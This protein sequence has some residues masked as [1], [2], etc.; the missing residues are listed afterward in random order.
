MS[1]EAERLKAGRRE[2]ARSRNMRQ[3][4]LRAARIVNR[5]V[6]E[7]LH[8]RGYG[9]L[10]STHTTLLSNMPLAGGTISETAERAGVTKQ[11]MGRLA[12][13]LQEAGYI[14]MTDDPADGRTKRLELTESGTRL[15]LDSL[16]VMRDLEDGYAELI[17][18]D[19][20]WAVLE[21]LR[22]FNDAMEDRRRP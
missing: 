16:D 14:R 12:A 10:R 7:G 5:D 9:N 21:G 19:R 22:A 18:R 2:E 17:G 20:L 1:Q 3:L 13:D 8:A 15:M 11:A 6:V 4:L